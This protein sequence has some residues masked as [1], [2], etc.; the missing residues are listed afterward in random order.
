MI[1]L[2]VIALSLLLLPISGGAAAPPVPVNATPDQVLVLYNLDWEKDVEGSEPGQ[3][4]KEVADYYVRMHTDPVT[5]KKPYLLGL[6][7]VH[8]KKHLN[9]WVIREDS[10]DNKN[11]VVF[12][13]KGAGPNVGEWARDSR[14]VEI[15]LDPEGE[16][17]AWESVHLW[18][19][20]DQRSDRKVVTPRVSGAPRRE[21][22]KE[23]F[24]AI[25]EGKPRCYRFD[26]HEYFSG[27]VWVGLTAQN[28]AGKTVKDLKIKY[29]DRDDFKFSAFGKDG[30]VDEKNF[31]E[32]VAVPVKRFLE[33]SKNAVKG[34]ADLKKH[35]LYIVVCHGLPFS[36]EGV[37][38][39]ERGVTSNPKDHG[40]LGSLEQRLQTLYY[41][42][43]TKIVP[44]VFSFYMRGGADSEKGV[45]NY[46][47]TSGMRYPMVARRWNPYMHPDTYSF[48]GNKQPPEFINIAPLSEVRKH[49][50][51]FLFAFGVSRIDGQGPGE[52][53]RLIDYS[54]YAS[55][56]LRP[57][58]DAA[59]RRRLEKERKTKITA[60]P[61]K[62]ALAEK[63]NKWGNEELKALGFI[64]VS[65]HGKDGIPF[66]KRLWDDVPGVED[67][68]ADAKEEASYLGYYPGGMDRT[69][70]SSNGWNMGRSADIWQQVDS[71]VT[72]SACGGPAYGGGPH[73][74][75]ASFWDNRI[76]MRYLFRGRDLGECFLLS[77]YYVNWSTS[78]IGDPLYSPDLSKTILDNRPP[79]VA[80]R[81]DIQVT[82]VPTIGKIAGMMTVPVVSTK[83]APE[84][85]T[86]RVYYAK[87]GQQQ[88][89]VGIWPIYSTRPH[90][91]LRDLEPETTYDFKPEL[92]DPY[93]NRSN[94]ADMSGAITVKTPGYQQEITRQSA[95]KRKN[96]W[97]FD[98][99]KLP[100]VNEQ[101]TI[102]I[103]FAAGQNGLIPAIESKQL[104]FKVKKWPDGRMDLS[105][106]VGGPVR[107]WFVKSF[108]A[109]GE[110]ASLVMRWRRFPLTREVLLVARDGAEFTLVA[111]VRTPW[112]KMVLGGGIDIKEDYDVKVLSAELMSNALVASETAC[113]ITVPPVSKADWVKANKSSIQPER[114]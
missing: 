37:F 40:D 68:R 88:M 103:T 12:I 27:T 36:C 112:E 70:V 86:L 64:P 9:D 80:S 21:G 62:I 106:G 91:I 32:D 81:E 38:G 16:D 74:T 93:G 30:V 26:A 31:Q 3:D 98:F 89:R 58:M 20:S 107:R 22:R 55:K 101:G 96:K 44:P 46:R 76:L 57:E 7:C 35:I 87:V 47:I 90:V 13:G 114:Y 18:C 108:L 92:T 97:A 51:E 11:G 10:Q 48:L 34:G 63:E 53:K 25:E 29:Y 102:V 99:F 6:T 42:W 94:L 56:F 67:G 24:P 39:I 28:R 17:I 4:S 50:P 104:N 2:S 71:G 41:G 110:T 61:K 5:G 75:N 83:A 54:L 72:V 60:F 78:L 73:I 8:G 84:V 109:K 111:D 14:Q 23:S 77:T 1:F 65:R 19:A 105:L 59:V 85:A 79:E 33:D 49:L 95:K 82:F 113:M 100:G 43:G 69:V 15:V 66:L 52:A 45:R